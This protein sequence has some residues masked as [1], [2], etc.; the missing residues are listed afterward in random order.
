VKIKKNCLVRKKAFKSH[1]LRRKT[2]KQ[3]RQL[4]APATIHK[5]DLSTFYYML[6]NH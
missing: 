4:S 6:P 2:T 1:L 3:L 5:S